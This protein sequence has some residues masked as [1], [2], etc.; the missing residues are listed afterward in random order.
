MNK[1]LLHFKVNE[2]SKLSTSS[3][4]KYFISTVHED[5]DDFFTNYTLTG[6][7]TFRLYND[8]YYI[9][10]KITDNEIVARGMGTNHKI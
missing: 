1:V 9:T 8:R 10:Y 2:L 5:R 7:N 6:D 3:T 4:F